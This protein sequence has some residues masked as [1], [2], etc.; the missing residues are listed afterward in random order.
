MQRSFANR[1]HVTNDRRC[2]AVRSIVISCASSPVEGS[3]DDEDK[4]AFEQPHCEEVCVD[5]EV[6]VTLS[7]IGGLLF[8][9]LNIP[10]AI[11]GWHRP[12]APS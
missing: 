12:H 9:T 10:E 7:S 11:K 4:E 6:Y 5:C 1:G 3:A 2:A 8:A